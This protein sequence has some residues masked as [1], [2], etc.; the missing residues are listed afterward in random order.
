MKISTVAIAVCVW[1]GGSHQT[2]SFEKQAI[3]L[4]QGTPVCDLDEN[5]SRLP[6]GAW[7]K[8]L[9]GRKGGVIWQLTEC[10]EPI[11]VRGGVKD[12]LPAC[13][14]AIAVLPGGI[15]VTV[16]IT[17]G[18]F[19]KGITGYPAFYRAVIELDN[20][21][22]QVRSLSDLPEML[23]TPESLPAALAAMKSLPINL[24]AV[25][26]NHSVVKLGFQ[27]DLLLT[28]PPIPNPMAKGLTEIELPPA[29]PISPQE[30]QKLLEKLE[31][32]VLRGRA[33]TRIKP[34]YPPSARKMN[35]TGQ[36]EVKVTISELGLVIDA[37]ALNGHL[38][39]RN[40]AV[41]AAR[42][43]VFKPTIVNGV[44][45]KVESILTFVFAPGE[46]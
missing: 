42:N 9:I 14:E 34:V 13:A 11:S 38:A 44:P 10:D 22:Y 28:L 24:P 23:R 39:L 36:V 19:K 40:A 16:A 1:I 4:V 45:V 7:F 6:F 20:K 26:S 41:E 29:P 18:T 30:P 27:T 8:Q 25:T 15:K 12:D 46:K 35:A 43:W 5:L 31:E 37:I 32:A 33:I 21:L 2:V 17:V 3:S